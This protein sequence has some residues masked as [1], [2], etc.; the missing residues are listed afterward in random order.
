MHLPKF[1]V[2]CDHVVYRMNVFVD[3]NLLDAMFPYVTNSNKQGLP[4]Q[5]HHE[6][7]IELIPFINKIGYNIIH[8][9]RI[10]NYIRAEE[11]GD[12]KLGIQ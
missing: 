12:S 11:N 6:E 4:F 8:N 2:S 3:L 7:K 1:L 5:S 10:Y 9:S